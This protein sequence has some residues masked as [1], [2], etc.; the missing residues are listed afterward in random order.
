MIQTHLKYL[1]AGKPLGEEATAEIFKAMIED[2]EITDAQIGSYLSFTAQRPLQVEELVAG[3]R[4]LR[5]NML[6]VETDLP[7]VDTCGTGGSGLDTF[8]TSTTVAFVVAGCGQAVAKHGNRAASSRS[9]SADLIEALGIP[10]EGVSVETLHRCLQKTNFCFIYARGHHLATKR[11]A[12]I[13]LELGFRT[14]FNFL[15]PMSNPAGAKFQLMGVSQP[16]MMQPMAQA[17]GTLG[18]EAALVV[19]GRE[20]LDEISPCGPT[21]VIEYRDGNTKRF[22]VVP[23]DFG[24]KR[25]ELSEIVGAPAQEM[26]S[27]VRG[28]LGGEPSAYLDLVTL[29]AGAAL[30][31]AGRARSIVDGMDQA[32]KSIESGAAAAVLEKVIEVMN[33]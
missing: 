14:I 13:R 30:F 15:G 6:A 22:E 10:L 28:V 16:E 1:A 8:S 7:V 12:S 18:S 27:R 25:R 3:A 4:S 32:K 31:I 26:A 24:L 33:E 21:E 20:G 2:G 11:V 5:E 17:L 29:N 23:E 9:G 19:R